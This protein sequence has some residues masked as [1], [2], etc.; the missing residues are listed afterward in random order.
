MQTFVNVA[1]VQ[2]VKECKHVVSHYL[3]T[4]TYLLLLVYFTYLGLDLREVFNQANAWHESKSCKVGMAI[5]FKKM[6]AMGRPIFVLT[7]STIGMTKLSPDLRTT[8][9]N[10]S[11]MT[12]H[13]CFSNAVSVGVDDVKVLPSRMSHQSTNIML[14]AQ[15]SI[16]FF[17]RTGCGH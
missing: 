4:T 9:T 8:E 14:P 1:N 5:P 12:L 2:I 17:P 15:D 7:S 6:N 3:L 16:V 11:K 13:R 10:F